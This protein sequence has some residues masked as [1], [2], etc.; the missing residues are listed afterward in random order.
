MDAAHR[1]AR[2]YAISDSRLVVSTGLVR[3][4]LLRHKNRS[5]RPASDHVAIRCHRRDCVLAVYINLPLFSLTFFFSTIF[6]PLLCCNDYVLL[7]DLFFFLSVEKNVLSSLL[8]ENAG[9]DFM[10]ETVMR[11][12]LRLGAFFL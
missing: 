4:P 5:E 11:Y 2:H 9:I 10:S 7:S 12:S 1:V 8:S 6:C 3:R